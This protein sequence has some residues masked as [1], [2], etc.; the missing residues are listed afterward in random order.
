MTTYL[1]V[2][3]TVPH[4]TGLPEHAV[5]NTWSFLG[6]SATR[7]IDASTI[8]VGLTTFYTAVKAYLSSQ[9]AWSSGVHE[10]IDMS[11]AKPRVPYTTRTMA[12]FGA[13]TTSSNDLPPEVALCISMS[14]APGSGLNARRR[15]GRVYIGPLQ[16]ADGAD[17]PTLANA[18]VDAFAAAAQDLMDLT[19]VELAVYSRS[20]HYGVPVGGDIKDYS[21]NPSLL[22]D[23]YS[24]VASIWVDNA[25]DTQ[26]RRGLA[27]S[28][29]KTEYATP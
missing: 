14:A 8:G 9:Y 6:N 26:R 23:S 18:I 24:Q 21:E 13:N 11:D 3:T 4:S 19:N 27:A 12:T 17:R 5:V 7:E 10:F 15:R 29:R 1:R 2:I 28:Y 22:D 16:L 25:W 20:T